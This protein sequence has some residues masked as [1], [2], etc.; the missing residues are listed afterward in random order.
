MTSLA[1][2]VATLLTNF[3]FVKQE[4]VHFIVSG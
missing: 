1:A 4:T 3:E 2:E